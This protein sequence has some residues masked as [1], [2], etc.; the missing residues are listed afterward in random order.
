MPAVHSEVTGLLAAA[1]MAGNL[2]FVLRPAPALPR[3]QTGAATST[4]GIGLRAWA[5]RR[6]STLLSVA[7]GL[8]NATVVGFGLHHAGYPLAASAAQGLTAGALS[9]FLQITHM[10]ERYS[11]Y[12]SRA[13]SE[14]H[15]LGKWLWFQALYYGLVKVAGIIVGGS[16]TTLGALVFSYA[17]TVTFGAAQ[18]P[19]AAAIACHR[20]LR[21][22]QGHRRS[23]VR[24]IADLQ[25]M[26]VSVVCV[27]ASALNSVGVPYTR[28]LLVIVGLAGLAHYASVKT[29]WRALTR[30]RH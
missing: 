17:V 8:L 4:Y 22:A 11:A 28:G 10:N 23:R 2:A 14:V 19:W 30:Q 21:L 20:G 29:R 16:A 9:G 27:G 3:A 24:F 5:R 18:Y 15:R 13:P 1:A 7:R 25:T 6:Y 12:L 26:A